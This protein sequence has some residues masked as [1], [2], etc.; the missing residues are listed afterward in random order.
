[1]PA[2][3]GRPAT[4]RHV[5]ITCL[6]SVFTNSNTKKRFASLKN[7]SSSLP[8][9][10]GGT[11]REGG[12][13]LGGGG[14]SKGTRLHT[15]HAGAGGP[16]RAPRRTRRKHRPHT[17]RGHGACT[18][19]TTLGW[20]S[21]FKMATSRMAVG[22]MPSLS[23]SSRIRFSATS[24]WCFKSTACTHRQP[25]RRW[26]W[27]CRLWRGE[28]GRRT[29]GGRKNMGG[30]VGR[31]AGGGRQQAKGDP[32]SHRAGTRAP[33]KNGGHTARQTKYPSC[34]GAADTPGG[35]GLE[36]VKGGGGGCAAGVPT[37][38]TTP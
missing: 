27:W 7:T 22:G 25:R 34:D 1:M 2:G 23:T 32:T 17:Q 19:R 5:S 20:F 38:Y 13:K 10:A 6:R 35:G 3:S 8:T 24:T 37:L 12:I 26:W 16:A 36:T 28:R 15:Q 33:G 29:G 30:Q 9:R 18:H 31:G 11:M 4:L 14:G 21:S